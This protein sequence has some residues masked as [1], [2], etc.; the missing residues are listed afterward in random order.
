TNYVSYVPHLEAVSFSM[1][2]MSAIGLVSYP[3]G[4]LLATFNGPDTVNEFGLDWEVQHGHHFAEDRLLV[5]NNTQSGTA[6][7]LGVTFDLDAATASQETVIAGG[8][9]SLAFGDIQQLDGGNLL[10][11]YST[12]GVM[13]EVDPAGNVDQRMEAS[14]A[15]GYAVRR[16]SLYGPPPPFGN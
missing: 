10:V 6:N 3:E 7:I 14:E 12:S 11:T 5:F 16:D 2:H 4:Q 13:E 8:G 1:R 9:T 15:I